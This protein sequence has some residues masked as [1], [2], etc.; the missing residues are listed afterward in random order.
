MKNR[1]GKLLCFPTPIA[2]PADPTVIVQIGNERFAIHF[3]FEDLPPA[4]PPVRLT[5][6]AKKVL[7]KI[8]K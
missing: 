6:A 1:K 3:E 2:E 5:A 7:S 8:K 4:T